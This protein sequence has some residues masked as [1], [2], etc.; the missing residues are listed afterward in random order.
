MSERANWQHPE[1]YRWLNPLVAGWNAAD[2]FVDTFT[3]AD[4][5]CRV[6]RSCQASESSVTL[7]GFKSM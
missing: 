6:V 5:L 7:Y 3:D 2:A 4:V 1:F